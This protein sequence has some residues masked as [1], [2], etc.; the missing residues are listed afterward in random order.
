MKRKELLFE[1][2]C[3][4]CDNYFLYCTHSG[5]DFRCY[6]CKKGMTLDDAKKE[7][8]EMSE[9]EYQSFISDIKEYEKEN[10]KIEG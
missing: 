2:R 8:E 5:N 3:K 7:L 9:E 6:D 1:F 10:G 4:L